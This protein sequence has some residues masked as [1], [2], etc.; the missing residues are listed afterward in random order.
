MKKLMMLGLMLTLTAS[1]VMVNKVSA[2][3]LSKEL[4]IV[5][6]ANNQELMER[7]KQI[8]DIAT[9][10]NLSNEDRSSLK[11]EAISIKKQIEAN[12]PTLVISLGAAL[13]V[14]IIIVL[15]VRPHREAVVVG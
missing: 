9:R 3:N 11:K 8:R 5:N 10:G 14:A 15:L 13:L 6:V 1:P 2:E 7:L 4:K 12:D